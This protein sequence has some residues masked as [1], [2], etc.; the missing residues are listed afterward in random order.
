MNI[1]LEIPDADLRRI[2][3]LMSEAKAPQSRFIDKASVASDPDPLLVSVKKAAEVL[4]IS[5][6]QYYEL[7]QDGKSL[8]TIDLY[9]ASTQW[10]QKVWGTGTLKSGSH[11]VIIAW[12][13]LKR[14]AAKSA[15]INVDA[16]EVTGTLE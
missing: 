7:V 16:V 12:T 15:D 4:S 3:S 8:G 11:T 14:A 9:S 10:Q 5:R 6:S 1:T 2:G 13:G